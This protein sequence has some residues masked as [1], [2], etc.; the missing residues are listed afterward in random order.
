LIA[1]GEWT[2]KDLE[3]SKLN[4]AKN[5]HGWFGP[6]S[7]QRKI[8]HSIEVARDLAEHGK[9]ALEQSDLA[10]ARRV[11]PLALSLSNSSEIEALNARLQEQ[12]KEE[13]LRLLNEQKRVAETQA[14]APKNREERQEKKPRA[15]TNGQE[16]KNIAQLMADF[17]IACH[18]KNFV[19]AQRLMSRLEKQGVDDEEFAQLSRDLADDVERHV[20]HLIKIGVI[21]YSRQQYEEALRVWKVAKVLDPKNEQLTARIKRVTRVIKNLQTLRLKSGAAR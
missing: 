10:A 8:G 18:E 12:L 15:T 14:T 6:Y 3:I 4:E 16:H 20:Q 2:L 5:P 21:H 13:E 17:K 11:L 9:R 19:E 1:K 7:L